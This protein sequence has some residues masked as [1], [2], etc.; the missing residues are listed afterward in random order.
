QGL[1]VLLEAASIVRSD[2]H[3]KFAI[4]GEGV[5]KHRLQDHAVA[6]GLKNLVF[7]GLAPRESFPSL[8]NAADVHLVIQRSEA[9]DTVMPSKL[10]NILSVGK[11]TIATASQGTTL[12]DVIEE[13]ET[14]L[15]VAPENG[16]AL[17]VA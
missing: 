15:T 11:P 5:A 13:H 17:A 14:G 7:R 4:A 3:I 6:L 9:A 1:E 16:A 12:F 8:L 10:T 2:T